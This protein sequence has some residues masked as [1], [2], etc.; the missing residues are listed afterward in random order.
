MTRDSL[1]RRAGVPFREGMGWDART[2]EQNRRYET[3]DPDEKLRFITEQA[4]AVEEGLSEDDAW[5][6]AWRRVTGGR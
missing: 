4:R 3:L 6:R 1:A 5:E 2:V